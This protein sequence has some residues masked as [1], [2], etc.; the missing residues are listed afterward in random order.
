MIAVC[1]IGIPSGCLNKAVTAN[2]SASA[3]IMPASA[4]ARTYPTHGAAPFDCA[5]VH[6]RKITVAPRRKDSATTFIRRRPR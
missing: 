2:Q 4:A 6:S 5:H 3:P 1:G